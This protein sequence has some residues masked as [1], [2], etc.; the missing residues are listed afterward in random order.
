MEGGDH[1]QLHFFGQIGSPDELDPV[2]EAFVGSF[3]QIQIGS[4]CPS[5]GSRIIVIDQEVISGIEGIL[6]AYIPLLGPEDELRSEG[7]GRLAVYLPGTLISGKQKSLEGQF[8][9]REAG[10]AV[11]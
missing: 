3:S 5:L 8:L 11:F 10:E 2:V 6:Q 4:I 1:L 7:Q 9:E